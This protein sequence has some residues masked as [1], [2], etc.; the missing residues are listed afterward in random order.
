MEWKRKL[1]IEEGVGKKASLPKA[2]LIFPSSEIQ[3]TSKPAQRPIYE[4]DYTQDGPTVST[5]DIVTP[6]APVLHSQV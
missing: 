4:T 3:V 2:P 5:V 1:L 6:Q